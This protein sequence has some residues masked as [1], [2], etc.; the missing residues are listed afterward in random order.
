MFIFRM[1][2]RQSDRITIGLIYGANCV[3]TVVASQGHKVLWTL[4]LVS[5]QIII[6]W[7]KGL[8]RPANKVIWRHI[9]IRYNLI[10]WRAILKHKVSNR[11]RCERQSA[12]KRLA[13]IRSLIY[14]LTFYLLIGKVN[15]ECTKSALR[16]KF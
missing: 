3:V 2:D 15:S 13:V 7:T 16:K 9:L 11:G 14:I 12:L 4:P 5:R 6:Y 10:H 1:R 8:Y